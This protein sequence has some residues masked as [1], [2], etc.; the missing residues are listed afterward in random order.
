MAV[1]GTTKMAVGGTTKIAVD[2]KTKRERKPAKVPKEDGTTGAPN[3]AVSNAGDYGTRH[4]SA[5]ARKGAR[6]TQGTYV[7][8]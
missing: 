2:G 6:N 4:Q 7:C 3:F 1:G 8:E 5:G